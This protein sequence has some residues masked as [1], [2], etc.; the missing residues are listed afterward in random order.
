MARGITIRALSTNSK[1]I[2]TCRAC[3]DSTN[4]VPPGYEQIRI[5]IHVKADCP[6]EDI[7]D[8]LAQLLTIQSSLCDLAY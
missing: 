1:A 7:D 6:D 8:L 4:S 3:S 5:R 2:S